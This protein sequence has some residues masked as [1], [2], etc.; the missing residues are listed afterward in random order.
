[1]TPWAIPASPDTDASPVLGPRRRPRVLVDA[2]PQCV[3]SR[4]RGCAR[5]ASEGSLDESP[6]RPDGIIVMTRRHKTS[7]PDRNPFTARVGTADQV[8]VD[9]LNALQTARQIDQSNRVTTRLENRL[10]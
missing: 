2:K 3:D 10:Q 5:P 4:G 7:L 9:N 1:M 6:S 8:T